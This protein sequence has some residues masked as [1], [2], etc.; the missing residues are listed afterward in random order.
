MIPY[1]NKYNLLIDSAQTRNWTKKSAPCYTERHHILPLCLGGTNVTNNLIVLTARE[2]YEAHR[3]LA[4]HHTDNK[5][6]WSAWW[7]MANTRSGIKIDSAEYAMLKEVFSQHQRE[8][9][10]GVPLSDKHKQNISNGSR[11]QPSPLRGRKL[12]DA[13]KHKISLSVSGP[14]NGNYGNTHSATTRSSM[15]LKSLLNRGI[16][17]ITPLGKFASATDAGKQHQLTSAAILYRVR[18]D[19]FSDYYKQEISEED[20]TFLCPEKVKF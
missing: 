6:L 7:C 13:T 10:T 15:K 8:L 18:S 11:G 4:L 1:L 20:I 3:L 2:H 12:S 19:T 16:M 9:K 14:K 5:Q 17:Y